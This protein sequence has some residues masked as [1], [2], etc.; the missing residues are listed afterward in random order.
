MRLRAFAG[1]QLSVVYCAAWSDNVRVSSEALRMCCRYCWVSGPVSAAVSSSAP[2][3]LGMS[4]CASASCP[5]YGSRA[6]QSA[7]MLSFHA[8]CNRELPADGG[9]N[10]TSTLQEALGG[11]TDQHTKQHKQ[12]TRTQKKRR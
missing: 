3:L 9:G 8:G 7:A 5:A 1:C 6:F 4:D 10:S 11:R 2:S 12:Q